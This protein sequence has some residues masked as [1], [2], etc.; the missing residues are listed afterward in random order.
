MK[1][2]YWTGT[3]YSELHVSIYDTKNAHYC[4]LVLKVDPTSQ[5]IIGIMHDGLAN[6]PRKELIEGLYTEKVI[7]KSVQEI[8]Q[9]IDVYN[10]IY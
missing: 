6:A 2:N 3:R 1:I 5:K 8:T 7:D 10:I 4:C 9:L